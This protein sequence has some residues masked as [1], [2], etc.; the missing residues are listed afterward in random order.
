MFQQVMMVSPVRKFVDHV[1]HSGQ[2]YTLEFHPGEHGWCKFCASVQ[3]F[4]VVLCA[5]MARLACDRL[6]WYSCLLLAAVNICDFNRISLRHILPLSMACSTA[7]TVVCTLLQPR[8]TM[9][10]TLKLYKLPDKPKTPGIRLLEKKDIPQVWFLV[11]PISDLLCCHMWS[12]AMTPS[13]PSPPKPGLAHA[14]IPKMAL[15][16]SPPHPLVL[17]RWH[18]LLSSSR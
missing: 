14:H 11:L 1:L 3:H 8:M 17:P 12:I 5:S 2:V 18:K 9:A 16:G 6:W 4:L 13:P 10:R 7:Q 15:L